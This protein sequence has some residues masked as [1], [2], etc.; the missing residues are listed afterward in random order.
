MLIIPVTSMAA[1]EYCRR[2]LY[3][4]K[5]LG[6]WEPAKEPTVLGSIRH[7]V[8]D[9]IGKE[10][11]SIVESIRPGDTR[12]IIEEKYSAAALRLLKKAIVEL[13]PKLE[14]AGLNQLD[15]YKKVKE[16]IIA[17]SQFRAGYVAAFA[18][19]SG[20]G[21][22][23]LWDKLTPKLLTELHIESES[24]G[25]RGIIDHIEHYGDHVVPIEMKTG[26]PPREGVWDSHKLQLGAYLLMLSEKKGENVAKGYVRYLDIGENRDV[27]MNAF[28]KMKITEL[29]ELVR[30]TLS[31]KE[32]PDYCG[33]ENKCK[34]CG[35]REK[36]YNQEL[37]SEIM[38]R[39]FGRTS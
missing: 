24:L 11:Q 38:N 32:L 33:N 36:C 25:F 1:Y 22:T 5:V 26:S 20:L 7:A 6:M 30:T 14:Q 27:V 18:A 12:E 2:K 16:P 34:N 29:A 37:M 13:K 9:Y 10:E 15:A 17:E 19:E 8:V 21:G 3:L 28:L 35:L 4:E 23:E 39:K 31:A